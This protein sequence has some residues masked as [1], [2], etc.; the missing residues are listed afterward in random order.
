MSPRERFAALARRPD[1]RIDLA[2]AALWIAAEACPGLTPGPWLERLR[3]LAEAA[4]PRLAGAAGPREQALRLA[5]FLFAEQGFQGNAAEYDDP[6]NSYLHEVLERR[7]GIPITL[8]LV[9]LEVGRRNGVAIEGIGFPGHFLVKVL[10]EDDEEVVLDPFRGLLLSEKECAERLAGALG[11]DARWERAW[12]R[13]ATPREI[14]VR[15]LQNLKR[16]HAARSEL[17]AA[18]GCC[19]RVLLLVPDAPGELRDRAIL[20]RELECFAPALA[21]LERFATLAPREATSREV[22]DLLHELREAV[23]RVH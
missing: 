2:E 15:M 17:E 12:L 21:D 13:A 9:L 11:S 6:R 23:T 1:A 7:T 4:A 20:W 8:A 10:G 18:I 22:R 16:A 5:R 3:R 14:L 19:D